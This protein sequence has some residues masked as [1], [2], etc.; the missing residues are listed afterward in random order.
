MQHILDRYRVGI[1]IVAINLQQGGVRP[2]EQVQ[3]AFDDVLKA[4]Q[5]RE[6]IKNEA[7]AY[8]N[9]VIPRAAGTASRLREEA[10]GYKSRIVAQAQGDAQRFKALYVEYQKAPQ[11]TRDRLYID[12]MQQIYSNVSKV[13]V[14]TRQGSNLLYLPLDKIMQ[15]TSAGGAAPTPAEAASSGAA[16]SALGT[17][18][19][20]PPTESRG[21]D[22]RQRDRDVR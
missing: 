9:D 22:G 2:P 20:A 18:P 6:R 3:A 7:Q 16:P 14:E 15:M 1:E 21:R 10:Q 8:A 19:S 4:G 13:L 11:V 12:T 17:L 5:E